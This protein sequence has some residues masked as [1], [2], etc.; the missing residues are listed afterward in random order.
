MKP[1]YLYRIP[2]TGYDNIFILKPPSPLGSPSLLD[3]NLN[4]FFFIKKKNRVP[5]Q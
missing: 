4:Y 2:Y 3:R 5:V 1:S